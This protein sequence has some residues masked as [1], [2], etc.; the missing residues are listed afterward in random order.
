LIPNSDSCSSNAY[1]KEEEEIIYFRRAIPT[2][3]KKE[4]RFSIAI[5]NWNIHETIL[6]SKKLKML[7][8]LPFNKYM[9]T[10][11]DYFDRKP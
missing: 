8:S 3:S 4:K 11:I 5:S 6:S 2:E 7:E 1:R 9:V 10:F